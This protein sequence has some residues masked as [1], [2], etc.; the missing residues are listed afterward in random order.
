MTRSSVQSRSTA[1]ES[2][3]T[4]FLAQKFW[5]REA[6]RMEGGGFR[7]LRARGVRGSIRKFFG[8]RIFSKGGLPLPQFFP[9][10]KRLL[11][12]YGQ[13]QPTRRG[14]VQ[15]GRYFLQSSGARS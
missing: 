13:V 3:L 14:L 11:S 6:P 5:R 8:G 1:Q 7:A 9:V 15:D 10:L 4:D 12:N 2:N